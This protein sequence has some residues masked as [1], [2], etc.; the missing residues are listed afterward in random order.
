VVLLGGLVGVGVVPLVAA[1]GAPIAVPAPFVA[2]ARALALSGAFLIQ[3]GSQGRPLLLLLLLLLQ[4]CAA[5]LR[6]G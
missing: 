5:W 1:V 2:A 3:V 6:R 4:P